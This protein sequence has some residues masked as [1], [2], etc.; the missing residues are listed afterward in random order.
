MNT[1]VLTPRMCLAAR[2]ET[3]PTETREGRCSGG[4]PSRGRMA[5]LREANAAVNQKR[6]H[7][8]GALLWKG[9]VLWHRI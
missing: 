4:A 8:F 5:E 2:V 9:P 1:S 3:A 7:I 6:T